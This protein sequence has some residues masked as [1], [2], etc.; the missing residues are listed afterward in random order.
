MLRWPRVTTYP[1]IMV[2]TSPISSGP[3]VGIVRLRTKDHGFFLLIQ[4]LRL[5]LSKGPN[6]LGVSLPLPQDKQI[7][8][9]K[10]CVLYYLEFRTMDEEHKSF[11]SE[12][13][14]SSAEAFNC[15]RTVSRYTFVINVV[16]YVALFG[17]NLSVATWLVKQEDWSTGIWNTYWSFPS[18]YDMWD[19]V[20]NPHIPDWVSNAM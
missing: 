5:A 12:C 11:D 4:W 6:S 19:F 1:Q 15:P 9:P 10:H 20:T 17:H 14:S 3:S 16:Q 7:Q 8:F 13:C 18:W 2:L